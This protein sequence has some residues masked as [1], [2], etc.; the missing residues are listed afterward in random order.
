[1]KRLVVDLE[2]DGLLQECTK[3]HCLAITD[4]DS[5]YSELFIHD[6]NGRIGQ[7]LDMLQQPDVTLIGHNIFM[8]D[9]EVFK[10]LYDID[11]TKTNPVHDTLVMAQVLFGNIKQLDYKM[12]TVSG[13]NYGLHSLAAWGE[14]VKCPKMEYTG[15]FFGYNETMG[16]Y[17]IQDTKVT[18][19][20]YLYLLSQ[21]E[22][23]TWK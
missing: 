7:A 1:M 15:G 22:S 3:I 14:R 10:K 2:T 13:S 17:C 20:I 11:F 12:F 21:V 8:F 19:E 6:G 23:R 9:N 5:D 16:T 18:K 4:I